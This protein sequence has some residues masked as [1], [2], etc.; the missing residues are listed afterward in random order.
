[1][2]VAIFGIIALCVLMS[3]GCS[4]DVQG[5]LYITQNYGNVQPQR[6]QFNGT[7]WG[8]LD[9]PEEG[10]MIVVGLGAWHGVTEELLNN[11]NGAARTFLQRSERDCAIDS[12]KLAS[13]TD[14]SLEYFYSC[15]N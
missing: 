1:M 4:K 9:K 6:I 15:K 11:A 5:D 14:G 8:V 13:G 3:A 2:R 7:D 10:R 12:R